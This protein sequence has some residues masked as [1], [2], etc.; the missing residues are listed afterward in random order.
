MTNALEQARAEVR[1]HPFG[2]DAYNEAFAKVQQITQKLADEA[3]GTF[4]HTS[5]DGDIFAPR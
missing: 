5:I 2:S 3:I 4:E 1:K